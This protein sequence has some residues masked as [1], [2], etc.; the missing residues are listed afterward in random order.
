MLCA[1]ESA[2]DSCD[3]FVSAAAVAYFRVEKPATEKRKRD[4]ASVSITLTPN[5]DIAATMGQR[6]RAGQLNIGFAAETQHVAEYGAKKLADKNF[7]LLC[8]NDV[9]GSEVGFGSD[10]HRAWLVAPGQEANDLGVISKD[11][12]AEAIFDAV[13]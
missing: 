8:A 13:Q 7:D 12:L 9:G 4:A 11:A 3:I 5:P 6:K 10:A 1:V 2:F